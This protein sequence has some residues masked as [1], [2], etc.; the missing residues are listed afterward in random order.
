MNKTN[1]SKI[2]VSSILLLSLLVTMISCGDGG[3][4]DT[5]LT[6]G[7]QNGVGD[8]VLAFDREDNEKAE[9][10]VLY[11]L[12][13]HYDEF[14]FR[15]ELDGTLMG[16]A[17]FERTVMVE[18]YLGIDI[19]PQPTNSIKDIATILRTNSMSGDDPYQIVLTHMY[20]GLT[21]IVS[22][23]YVLDLYDLEYLSFD[24]DYWNL[25][26]IEA[27]EVQSKA[28][29]A[30]ND[31]MLS[32]P[33]AVMF[34]KQM[35]MDFKIEDLYDLVRDGK[36][37]LEKMFE[38]AS[39]VSGGT[40]DESGTYGFTC[41]ADWPLWA[42]IDSCDITVIKSEDGYKK[43]D[44][45]TKNERY[46][47]LF[48]TMMDSFDDDYN[49][50]YRKDKGVLNITSGQTLLSVE[51]VG[52]AY[53]YMSSDVKFGFLPYPKYD[54][55][56]DQYRS[57]DWSG[58][59]CIP[60]TVKNVEL[61]A[62]TV[63]CLAFFSGDTV[64]DAYYEH[65]LGLRVSEAPD[66]AEMLK[67]IFNN[68]VSNVIFNYRRTSDGLAYLSEAIH[69]GIRDQIDGKNYDSVSYLWG[70]YGKQAQKGL[71]AILN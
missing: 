60:S 30:T 58:F 49:Y 34:N 69:A 46:L 9:I 52:D 45:S 35:A 12:W 57:Y 66:D 43:L 25:E 41:L 2:V 18:D 44:M 6:T 5:T 36:W 54:E 67:T 3:G 65:L 1:L 59:L 28:Y 17:I 40:G 23:G 68:T 70:T 39:Q 8:K 55:D 16:S 56:Q 63:E 10:N 38:I 19:V 33:N 7:S 42:F 24:E 71:D 29:L 50:Y 20:E 13:G 15:E 37:T 31:Y 11:P 51:R 4:S 48:E 64:C 26:A 14:F 21:S 62:K 32:D 22:E 47:N 61:T 27:V 53:Q